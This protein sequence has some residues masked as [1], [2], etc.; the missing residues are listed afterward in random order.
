MGNSVYFS[1]FMTK[2]RLMVAF[3]SNDGPNLK[4]VKLCW[5]RWNGPILM[6]I[7]DKQCEIIQKKSMEQ[8]KLPDSVFLQGDVMSSV[9]KTQKNTETR[10]T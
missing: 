5:K 10:Q 3:D 4:V 8:L 2:N 1:V 6:H 7:Y 9:L